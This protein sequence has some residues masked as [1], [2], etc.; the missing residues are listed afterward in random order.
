MIRKHHNETYIL[1]VKI[2]PLQSMG[3][4]FSHLLEVTM[5]SLEAE[6]M[7]KKVINTDFPTINHSNLN[8]N[9]TVSGLSSEQTIVLNIIKKY[10]DDERG[11]E[12][13]KIKEQVPANIINKV[14]EI[15]EFLSSEGHL[16]TTV[17]DD[18]FKCI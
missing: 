7:S 6:K 13:I 11:A 8:L 17:T 2:K 14:D 15:L 18:V 5:I 10:A 1:A 16:Y 4:L 12:R 3:E 9:S